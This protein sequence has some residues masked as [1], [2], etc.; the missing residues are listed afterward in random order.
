MAAHAYFLLRHQVTLRRRPRPQREPEA[1]AACQPERV[2]EA[3]GDQEA[4]TLVEKTISDAMVGTDPMAVA[5]WP[6]G[7]PRH[8]DLSPIN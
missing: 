8:L 4:Q 3:Y 1:G 6:P 5:R 7:D 2:W